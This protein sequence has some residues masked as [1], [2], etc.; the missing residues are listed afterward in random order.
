MALSSVSIANA[1]DNLDIENFDF[2]KIKSD[3]DNFWNT[4]LTKIKVE[5][6]IDSLKTMFYTAMYHA[7]LAPVTFSDKNGEYRKEK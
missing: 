6:P 5:T 2:E 7:Q 3:G 1:K 4:A